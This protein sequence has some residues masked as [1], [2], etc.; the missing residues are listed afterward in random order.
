MVKNMHSSSTG[1]NGKPREAQGQ[2]QKTKR[3]V[4][5]DNKKRKLD[6]AKHH[7]KH[8]YQKEKARPLT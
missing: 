2:Y 4:R 8:Q 3:Q 1:Q 5:L 7:G 6:L